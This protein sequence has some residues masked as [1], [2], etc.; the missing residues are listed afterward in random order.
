MATAEALAKKLDDAFQEAYRA[1]EEMRIRYQAG[2]NISAT[3]LEFKR[4][5][6]VLAGKVSARAQMALGQLPSE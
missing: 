2:E 5:D 1:Y 4:Q 3:A 6:Y